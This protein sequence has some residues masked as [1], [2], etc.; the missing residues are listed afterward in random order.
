VKVFKFKLLEIPQQ[1]EDSN[2]IFYDLEDSEFY[3]FSIDPHYLPFK[4][5]WMMMA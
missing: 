1:T 3:L 2:I 5:L 4:I